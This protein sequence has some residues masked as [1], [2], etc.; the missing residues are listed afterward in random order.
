[1]CAMLAATGGVAGCASKKP[2]HTVTVTVTPARTSST[3]APG[4][5]SASASASPTSST[6][7]SLG[8]TCD[9]L[10]PASSVVD[11]IGGKGLDGADAFVVGDAQ[12]DI[13]RLAYVNCRYGVT[14]TG[15][16]AKSKIEVGVS[17][18]STPA[19]AATRVSATLDDYTAHGARATDTM[20]DSAPAK[21]LSGGTGADYEAPVLVLSADQRTVAVTIAPA[22]ATGS[23]AT[24]DAVALAK[25]V[26]SKTAA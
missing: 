13:G 11:A 26:L 10:L 14:G 17:L 25:L 24:K 21:L 16:A 12:K 6:R 2:G 22:V 7:T 1:M 23:T 5:S 3:A 8:G 19:A 9:T 15:A 4:S 18:Y 20:V